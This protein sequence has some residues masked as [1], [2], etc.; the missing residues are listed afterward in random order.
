MSQEF[1]LK[2][3][4]ETRY[5]FLE[6]IEQS[7]LV[8]KRHK[9]VFTTLNYIEHVLIVASTITGCISISAFPSLFGISI[10]IT[11]STIALKTFAV[12]AGI[13]K[14]MSIIKKKKKKHDKILLLAKSK[15]NSIEVLISKGLIDSVISRDEFV[16]INIVLKEY[17]EMKEEIKKLKT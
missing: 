6:E 10:G 2:H 14:Y 4:N 1:R 3:I 5:Y 13:K 11:S 9:K 8:S 15:S 16:L 17:D 12:A 7:E